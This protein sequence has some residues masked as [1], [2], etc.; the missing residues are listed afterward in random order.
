VS[1]YPDIRATASDERIGFQTE[2]GSVYELRRTSSAMTWQRVSATLA[3]GVLRS[4]GG[5]LVSWPQVSVG[6]RCHLL[7]EPM[8]RSF[9][10]L[11]STSLVVAMLDSA[12]RAVPATAAD[13]RRTFGYLSVGAWVT[14]AAAGQHIGHW[15]VSAVDDRLVHCG[16][17]TFDRVTGIEVD[18]ELGLGPGGRIGAWLVHPNDEDEG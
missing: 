8:N 3:S 5:V 4:E 17:W 2:T 9:T 11:V 10:R 18:P 6:A 7:C 16:V 14:L 12:G 1:S 15:Q 13:A